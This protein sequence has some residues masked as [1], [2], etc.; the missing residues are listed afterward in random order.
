MSIN[1][2]LMKESTQVGQLHDGMLFFTKINDVLI[3][4][5]TWMNPENSMLGEKSSHN[6]SCI[7]CLHLEEMFRIGES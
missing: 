1:C 7:T 2:Q 3:D 5:A 4:A 6:R